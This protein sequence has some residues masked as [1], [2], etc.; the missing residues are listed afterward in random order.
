MHSIR[1]GRWNSDSSFIRHWWM[2]SVV[3]FWTLRAKKGLDTDSVTAAAV[4]IV[5]GE[6]QLRFELTIPAMLVECGAG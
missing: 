2:S 1:E 5:S 6:R 4:V 3:R